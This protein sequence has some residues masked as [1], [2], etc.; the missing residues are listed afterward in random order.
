MAST[1]FGLTIAGSGLT[2]YNAA[3][4]VTANNVS[5]VNTEGYTR[6][7]V[8]Q[9]AAEALRANA[10]YGMIGSGT[11]A[12]DIRQIRDLYYDNKYW[13]SSCKYGEYDTKYTYLQQI[14]AAFQDD[15]TIVGFS[16]IFDSMNNAL[17]DL[18]TNPMDDSFRNQ[19]IN[20]A[21][22]LCEYFN[23]TYNTLLNIQKDAN[24]VIYAKVQEINSIANEMALLNR[25]INAIEVTGT[26]ANELRD[27]RALLVDKLSAMVPIETE[28]L[29]IINSHDPNYRTGATTYKVTI[30]GHTLV[31]NHSYNQ[32]ECVPRSY[33]TCQTDPEGLFDVIWENDKS[34][35]S[36]A[37]NAMTGE[38]K[39]L[40]DVRDGNNLMNFSGKVQSISTKDVMN[41]ETGYL[42]SLTV[43]T[44]S[45]PNQ[46]EIEKLTLGES[47][48]IKL[49]NTY[50]NY[51]DFTMN[52]DGTFSFTLD[53]TILSRDLYVGGTANVG[54]S[55]DFKGVPY[56]MQ[57]M[58]AFIRTYAE[59]MNDI[60]SSGQNAYGKEAGLF[61]TGLNEFS[62]EEYAFTETL[63]SSTG[64]SYYKLTAANFKVR[65]DLFREPK[66]LSTSSD[67]TKGDEFKDI[68]EKMQELYDKK[69][70][71]R[72]ASASKFLE[73]MLS[74]IAIDT[75]KMKTFSD[76]Y[77]NIME[78]IKT[79]RLSISG[80]DED[81]EAM[82]L[83]KFQNAYN[84]S[85]RMVQCMSE[86]YNRLILETGV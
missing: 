79:Q 25:Q 74:D 84:F 71:F 38:L 24:S 20:Y 21:E 54:D 11:E 80:V 63:A 9:K 53:E 81:E 23:Q 15:D 72:G 52:S 26:K 48:R 45:K 8:D 59:V 39:A 44:V 64:D 62:G 76:N 35:V 34:I 12:T 41:P 17:E 65:E 42:E 5:N 29:E 7:V 73:T 86:I 30:M 16:S 57:Q 78:S 70:I 58:N 10:K 6:Q 51:T 2:A 60:H 50:F 40:F 33:S 31:D 83:I 47:G 82:N 27:Q 69:Q 66:N 85:S 55:I 13:N 14:E 4:N 3:I 67:V 68:V 32:L 43:V 37:S 49:D 28:E 19:F 56:Y 46:S 18:S 75:N 1:F 36:L 61:F 77:T 22:S